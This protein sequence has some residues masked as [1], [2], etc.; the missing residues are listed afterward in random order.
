MNFVKNEYVDV[1]D[2]LK[3]IG[4]NM[5][6]YK[7]L[8]ERFVKGDHLSELNNAFEKKDMDE[9]RRAAHTLK[10]IAANLSLIKLW[11]GSAALELSVKEGLDHTAALGDIN[12]VYTATVQIISE[13]IA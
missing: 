2:A 1:D 8:L 12:Q 9:A 3:R 4:G 5:G 11:E 10:G 7:T 6:L 13:I